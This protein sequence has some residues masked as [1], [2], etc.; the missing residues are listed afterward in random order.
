MRRV[1]YFTLI[2]LLVVIAI[3]AILAAMLLPA[4]S[5]A[6]EK[7][8]QITCTNN[9]KQIGLGFSMYHPDYDDYYPPNTLDYFG[10]NNK[11]YWNW[12][13]AMSLNGY[14]DV[15]NRGAIWKCPTAQGMLT[16]DYTVGSRSDLA[17]EMASTSATAAC[18][19]TYIAY[20]Y[21]NYYIGSKWNCYPGISFNATNNAQLRHPPVK[22]SEMKKTSSCLVMAEGKS[23]SQ[24][25]FIIYSN[26]RSILSPHNDGCNIL[27]A[28]G[29]VSHMPNPEV[30]LNRDDV[31]A[32]EK[33]Y[34][35]K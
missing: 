22:L 11:N 31:A 23:Q 3:I 8:R 4:L 1:I 30:H 32:N 9:M 19:F 20:G 28:D 15:G 13:Y 7:A 33:Y 2:E 12:A 27:W 14:V 18:A 21:S 10:G 24:G 34:V 26:G 5:K 25:N 29:H 35:W 6:R 16:H 17:K